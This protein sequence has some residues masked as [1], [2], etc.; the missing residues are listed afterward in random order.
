MEIETRIVGDV[1]I[2]ELSGRVAFDERLHQTVDRLLDLGQRNLAID[3]QRVRYIDSAGL[4]AL[5]RAYTAVAKRGGRLEL[6]G[7]KGLPD[8]LGSWWPR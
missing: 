2:V 8:L 5:V 7:V 4:G 1:A 6:Q 3:L